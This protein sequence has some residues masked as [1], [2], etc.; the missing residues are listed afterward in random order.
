MEGIK[1]RVDNV[2]SLNKLG[3]VTYLPVRTN[4]WYTFINLTHISILKKKEWCI[5]G[6]TFGVR[7]ILVAWHYDRYIWDR[8]LESPAYGLIAGVCPTRVAVVQ[9]GSVALLKGDGELLKQVHGG[10][11]LIFPSTLQLSP[12]NGAN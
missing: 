10:D 2:K 8:G 1:T 12:C 11:G 7:A 5:S 9:E 6:I 4:F 3:A